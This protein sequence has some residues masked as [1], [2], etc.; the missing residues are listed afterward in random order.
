MGYSIDLDIMDFYLIGDSIASIIG[1]GLLITY[2]ILKFFLALLRVGR[3]NL[4]SDNR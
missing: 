2:L 1:R 3:E 4:H